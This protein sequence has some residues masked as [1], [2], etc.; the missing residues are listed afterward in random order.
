MNIQNEIILNQNNE[1]ELNVDKIVNYWIEM[2]ENDFN[3][4][5][6]F[7]NIKRY[8]WAL[9]IG[10]LVIEKLIKATY[11]KIHHKHPPFLHDLLKLI[12]KCNIQI[13]D[14]QMDI[15]DNITT[16]NINARYDDYKLAFYKQCT[17]EY[18][19]I[20][21]NHIKNIRQWIIDTQLT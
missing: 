11:V 15:I 12:N 21:M 5:I 19:E 14:E 7:F 13:T 3:S 18:T 2:S 9:F 4:M 8:N 1:S 16:F 10:H 17:F 6:D 20:W